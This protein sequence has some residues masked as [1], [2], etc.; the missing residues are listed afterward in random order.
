MIRRRTGRN[1]IQWQGPREGGQ[2]GSPYNGRKK[3]FEIYRAVYPV[4]KL[5]AA[6][7]FLWAPVTGSVIATV[8]DNSYRRRRDNKLFGEKMKKRISVILLLLVIGLGVL[9]HFKFVNFTYNQWPGYFC[10]G[11][12]P[13]SVGLEAGYPW[14]SYLNHGT[15]FDSITYEAPSSDSAPKRS[16]PMATLFGKFGY[17]LRR[18]PEHSLLLHVG[19]PLWAVAAALIACIFTTQTPNKGRQAMASPSPAT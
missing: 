14:I 17:E 13:G 9:S 10:I 12:S 19:F 18:P 15:R 11:I 2:K 7:A 4:P 5:S 3:L 6:S 8:P 1:G 16:A